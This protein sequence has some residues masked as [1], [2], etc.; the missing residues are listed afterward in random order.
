MNSVRQA[1]AE[2][3]SRE[4]VYNVQTMNQ[5]VSNSF[6][7]RRLSML[8]LAVFASL[9]LVLACVGIYGVI[10]YLVGQRT[11]EIGVRVA[12]G[13]QQSDVLK[14]VLGHGAKMALLGVAVG[15]LAALALT[16]LM[17]NQLFGVSP[18]DPLTFAAVAT[19]LMFVALAACYLPARRATRVDPII[20]LRHD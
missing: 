2:I 4:L 8:L 5:V 13:A 3:D 19:L 12:L 16:R 11:H 14:L 15:L 6:A 9:A 1:V 10:S 7:A 17:S 20:A 18:H